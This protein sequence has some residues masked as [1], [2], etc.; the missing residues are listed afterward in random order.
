[1]TPLPVLQGLTA[2]LGTLLERGTPVSTE[3]NTNSKSNKINTVIE[4][5]FL[6]FSLEHKIK[7]P[8]VNLMGFREITAEI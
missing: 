1:M 5:F 6:N 7:I 4:L 2:A 3:V 8:W